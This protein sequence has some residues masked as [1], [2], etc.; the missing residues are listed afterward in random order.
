M[1]DV[2]WRV[3]MKVI[4]VFV[5]VVIVLTLIVGCSYNATEE[6]SKLSKL[7]TENGLLKEQI[8]QLIGEKNKTQV[9]ALNEPLL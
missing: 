1:N 8:T 2:R 3:F 9:V 7:E 4:K 6:Q 5:L